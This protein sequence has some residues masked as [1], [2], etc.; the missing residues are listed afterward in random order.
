MRSLRVRS[1]DGGTVR[2]RN[3]PWSG[4][5]TDDVRRRLIVS[6]V[7]CASSARGRYL[8]LRRPVVRPPS[9]PRAHGWSKSLVLRCRAGNDRFST[10]GRGPNRQ[11]L[12]RAMQYGREEV[13]R[14]RRP[15]P[16][17]SVE[18][19]LE[20]RRARS[21][22]GSSCVVSVEAI[23]RYSQVLRGTGAESLERRPANIDATTTNGLL[24]LLLLMLQL[25]V[26]SFVRCT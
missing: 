19:S 26:S 16:P 15:R 5:P 21:E 17:R 4:V 24:R 6:T 20:S 1:F 25:L 7:D 12:V 2:R 9:L 8:G 23:T 13:T 14:R 10:R 11:T 22:G 18:M 3:C